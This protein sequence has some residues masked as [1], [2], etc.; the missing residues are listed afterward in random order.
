MKNTNAKSNKKKA[1]AASILAAMLA[2]TAV[3]GTTAYFTDHPS[4]VNTFTVGSVETELHEDG[5][6][7]EDPDGDGTSDEA[8]NIT[9]GKTI[10]KD[11]SIKNTGAN[12]AYVYLKVTVPMASVVTVDAQGNR[13]PEANTQLFTYTADSNWTL[14]STTYDT[15]SVS[16]AKSVDY[17]YA[18]NT[19]LTAGEETTSLFE[20]VTFANIIEG[21]ID[22]STELDV[23][24]GSM[25][26]QADDTGSAA[27]ALEKYY[28]QNQGVD[29]AYPDDYSDTGVADYQ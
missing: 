1:I 22:P 19:A 23:K 25:S 10:T 26:I 9:P 28:N 4:K 13:Q 21:E 6:F 29:F 18:Y 17:V 5:W 15:G 8:I 12:D 7:E 14:M 2:T 11:P 16:T 20:T 27:E 24:V 3:V